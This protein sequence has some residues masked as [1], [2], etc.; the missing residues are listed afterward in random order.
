MCLEISARLFTMCILPKH[1]WTRIC[2]VSGHS[3]TLS[4]GQV[5]LVL[6]FSI[7]AHL[8]TALFY[9]QCLSCT[10]FQKLTKQRLER[11]ANCRLGGQAGGGLCKTRGYLVS[12]SPGSQLL[13]SEGSFFFCP[14]CEF[15]FPPS[16]VLLWSPIFYYMLTII[17]SNL[18]K[19]NCLH[20]LL[21]FKKQHTIIPL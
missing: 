17:Y 9:H 4:H 20:N 6:L 19:C 11:Q 12:C 15:T 21:Q 8:H 16:S 1:W 5:G 2:F 18:E 3:Y 7:S 13:Q 14:T 10:E